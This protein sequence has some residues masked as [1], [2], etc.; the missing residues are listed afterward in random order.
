[1]TTW[2]REGVVDSGRGVQKGLILLIYNE[3]AMTCWKLPMY[4]WFRMPN[5]S[6]IASSSLRGG[7]ALRIRTSI[8][9]HTEHNFKRNPKSSSASVGAHGESRIWASDAIMFTE[10]FLLI[11]PPSSITQICVHF[12]CTQPDTDNKVTMPSI[13]LF[14]APA[15]QDSQLLPKAADH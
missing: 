9:F 8:R 3:Y 7:P 14:T 11:H 12:T 1:M 2:C 5:R 10:I 4:K 13:L 15:P 6:D